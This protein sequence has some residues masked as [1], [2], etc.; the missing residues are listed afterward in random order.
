MNAHEFNFKYQDYLEAGF[1]GMDI[2]IPEVISYLDEEFEKE[3][4]INP[5]FKYSQI[6]TK[7]GMARI[8]VENCNKDG[9][10]EKQVDEIIKHIK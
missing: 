7:F 9:L 5:K 3:I 6:K 4:A 2:H 10:W 1:Y 8:Y